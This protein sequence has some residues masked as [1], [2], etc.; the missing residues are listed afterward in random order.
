MV[1]EFPRRRR[2]STRQSNIWLCTCTIIN[3]PRP[4]AMSI[5]VR[6]FNLNLVDER[7]KF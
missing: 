5:L 4:H 1:E 7:L 2:I 6:R 3:D